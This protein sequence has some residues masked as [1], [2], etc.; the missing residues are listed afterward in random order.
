MT[1]LYIANMN[2]IHTN[3][4]HFYFEQAN[5]KL[6]EAIQAFGKSMHFSK[7]YP[8]YLRGDMVLVYIFSINPSINMQIFM[9]KNPIFTKYFSLIC[10]TDNKF[11]L[12]CHVKSLC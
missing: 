4:E 7:V 2:E 8:Y 9:S 11:R 3:S 1:G 10:D 12:Y 6:H 5:R